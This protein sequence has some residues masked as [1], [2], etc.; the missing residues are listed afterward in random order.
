MRIGVDIGGMSVKIGLVE[1]QGIVSREV[2]KT[3]SD[4]QTPYELIEK[5][6][7][8]V[9]MLL[10]NK[11]TV[12][13]CDGLGI[14]CPGTVDAESVLSHIPIISDGKMSRYLASCDRDSIF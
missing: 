3:D 4:G 12:G 11:L 2:I 10:K 6:A 7:D 9:E 13:E 1:G 8:V 5:I 14:A